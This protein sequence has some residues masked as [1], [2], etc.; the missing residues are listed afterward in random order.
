MNNQNYWDGFYA[1]SHADITEP[2]S[3]GRLCASLI[4]RD[5]SVFEVGCGNGRDALH[6][7]RCGLQ[8]F[9]SDPSRVALAGIRTRLEREPFLHRPR[10][11]ARPMEDLDDRHAGEL[12][13]VYMRFVLHAV[14]AEV[15]SAGLR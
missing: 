15:V 5:S 12:G 6:L 13:A 11:I 3:F 7:A 2:S 1:Q 14:T 9:A 10:L 8:V 4:L